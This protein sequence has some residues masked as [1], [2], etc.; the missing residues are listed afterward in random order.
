VARGGL[1]ASYRGIN[2]IKARTKQT[3]LHYQQKE[4]AENQKGEEKKRRAQFVYP[5]F[6]FHHTHHH[7]IIIITTQLLLLGLYV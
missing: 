4:H 6:P 5:S 2:K 1:S 7:I 3:M